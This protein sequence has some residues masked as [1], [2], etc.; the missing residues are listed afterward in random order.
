MFGEIYLL[1]CTI[2]RKFLDNITD[3]TTLDNAMHNLKGIGT[4]CY[5]NFVK[6]TIAGVRDSLMGYG[7]YDQQR[8][9]FHACMPVEFAPAYASSARRTPKVCMRPPGTADSSHCSPEFSI[10]RKM[11]R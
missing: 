11:I 10:Y 3:V 6:D 1:F 4:K 9:L 2:Y 5:L 7:S 8:R